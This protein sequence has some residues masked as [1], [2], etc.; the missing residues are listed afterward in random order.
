LAAYDFWQERQRFAAEHPRPKLS[1]E[2]IAA[3]SKAW[4]HYNDRMQLERQK[5]TQEKSGNATCPSC[6]T[7]FC[8]SHDALE[9]INTRLVEL[10]PCDRPDVS[11]SD[12]L[13]EANRNADWDTDQTVSAWYA[14]ES[15]VEAPKPA[16]PPDGRR[17]NRGRR[18]Y[19]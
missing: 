11:T 6:K 14:L 16:P 18:V 5:A 17:I 12:L 9:P 1:C 7:S 13:T 15:V 10:G 2:E 4:D 8:L 3:K 19:H